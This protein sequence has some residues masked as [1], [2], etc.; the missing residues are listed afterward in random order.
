M[1]PSGNTV[2]E[3]GDTVYF[4]G[5]RRLVDRSLFYVQAE[6]EPLQRVM[7]VGAT[8]LGVELA[9]DLCRGADQGQ[10]G[11]S[12]SGALPA[13]QRAAAPHA[14]PEHRSG[15]FA[16]ADRRGDRRDG[17]LRRRRPRRGSQH[18]ELPARAPPGR[19]PHG[20]PGQPDRLRRA[21]CRS[22]A[23][24]RRS[25]PGGRP[26]RRSPASSSAGPWSRPS[27]S[28][29]PAPRSCSTAST[30]SHPAVGVPLAQLGFPRQAVIGAVIKKNGV[31]TP[32]GKTVLKPGD[33]VLVFTLPDCL[34][35]VDRFFTARRRAP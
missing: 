19:R 13:G 26:P 2:L 30:R 32:G 4:T 15:R 23:S 29:S 6:Q 34:E 33:E 17:R 11:R 3:P 9:R 14:G 7:I 20:L 1:I 22:S 21:A 10:A 5:T 35:E 18:P 24:T 16:A 28:A 8:P 25:R 31:E 27:R 12:R